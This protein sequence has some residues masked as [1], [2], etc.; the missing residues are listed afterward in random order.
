LE[1]SFLESLIRDIPDFPKEGILFKDITPLLANPNARK[2]VV[3]TIAEFY[4]DS[5]IE[6][7]IAVE[8]RGFIF[9]SLVAASLNVPFIPVRKQGKLPYKTLSQRYDL[10]Y[11][12]NCLEIHQ[13]A[14]QSGQRVLIHDDL[15]ATGGTAIAAAQLASKLGA[16][17][18]DFS[19]ILNLSFLGGEQ[20]IKDQYERAPHYIIKY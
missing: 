4:K 11:G 3:N 9:G 16:T 20:R 5:N 12:S 2:Q 1:N 7:I 17:I 13:D 18:V 19:F 15:L 8:A 10:E 14:L 6:A